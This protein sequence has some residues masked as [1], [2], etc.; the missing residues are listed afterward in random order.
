MIHPAELTG[1][2]NNNSI[3]VRIVYGDV[4][5]LMT[6]DTEVEAEVAMLR[7]GHDLSA[8]VL[9]LGHHG[10]RTSST[11]AFLQAIRPEVAV[12]SAGRDNPYGHPHLETLRTV[13][14][15]GIPL[16]GTDLF[17]TIRVVT[18]GREYTVVTERDG[19]EAATN[20]GTQFAPGSPIGSASRC[21]PP[22]IDINT[23]T[24]DELVRIVHVGPTLASRIVAARPFQ[25][26]DDLTR[27][28]GI[29]EG[30]LADIVQQG[31]ACV[32]AGH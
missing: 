4:A 18:D 17:G 32:D 16:Y 20:G 30:R 10:S 23:A 31:L 7:R 11:M 8:R 1:D 5:F 2:F 3:V 19:S 9:K 6:G 13:A 24:I 25:S 21:A 29:A 22:L 27:V 14:S 26:V 15:L 12:Y 28:S